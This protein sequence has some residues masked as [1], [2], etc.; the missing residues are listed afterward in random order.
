MPGQLVFQLASEL[1]PVLIENRSVECRL[2]GLAI[3]VPGASAG[4]ARH[5]SDLQFLK[6]HDS[7]VLADPCREFVNTIQPLIRKARVN[8]LNATAR[9]APVLSEFATTAQST[10]SPPQRDDKLRV[11]SG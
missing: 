2:I 4:S 5:V 11:G 10:F 7:V 8:P 1:V 3:D 9:C 6:A